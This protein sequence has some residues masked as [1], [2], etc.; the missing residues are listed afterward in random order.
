[1]SAFTDI[2]DRGWVAALPERLRPFAQLARLDRPIGTWL[3]LFPCWWGLA[4][5]H[6]FDIDLYL[7]FGIG[8][9]VMR[10]AGCTVNDIWDRKLDA[11]VERTARRPLASGAVTLAGAL[12]FL[13][14]QLL[15]ALAVAIALGRLAVILAACSLV[16]VA[17]YPLA[18][19]VTWWPQLMLGFT[20][21]WGAVMAFAVVT[22]GVGLPPLL[23]YAAG[24]FWTLGYDT[25]YAHQDKQDD[26]AI[27]IRS[28]ALL[29]GEQSKGW[30]AVC[31]AATV[32]LI[33]AAGFSAEHRWAIV[34][35]GGIA[36]LHFAWQVLTVDLDDPANCLSR[37]QSNRW[38]G[39]I[40]L[41]GLLETW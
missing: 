20:F 36:A 29:W 21:N 15:V 5:A 31:Y 12:M 34:V 10:G 41:V 22:G 14:L 33:I 35:A 39:W 4:L 19:R 32:A 37:F 40:I 18:K 11:Q 9:V 2:P 1:M 27:G 28:T 3:L 6:S 23:L 7:L 25:I 16:L 17:T 24:I 26:K 30:I 38:I 8:A 13:V